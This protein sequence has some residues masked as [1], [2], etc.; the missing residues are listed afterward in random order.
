[1]DLHISKRGR[2]IGQM[3]P[4]NGHIWFVWI[5]Q[6]RRNVYIYT[7]WCMTWPGKVSDTW[8]FFN[9][10]HWKWKM[11]KSLHTKKGNM[12]TL[13]NVFYMFVLYTIWKIVKY[14]CEHWAC[15]NL[16]LLLC[17]SVHFCFPFQ[18]GI[19]ACQFLATR[20]VK[21]CMYMCHILL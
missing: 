16:S 12:I 5:N 4:W 2:A 9:S 10:G 19:A 18:R 3:G 21:L 14:E 20:N 11:N 7:L 1:M 13:R 6:L 15:K 8:N 17:P